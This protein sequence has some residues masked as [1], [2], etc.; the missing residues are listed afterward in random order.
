MAA[1]VEY[2]STPISSVTINSGTT[3]VWLDIGHA[4]M[5]MNGDHAWIVIASTPAGSP[6][7]VE[8][9]SSENS[10]DERP[11]ILINYTD[12]HSV[13]ISPSGSTTDADTQVQ[14]SHILN[15][16]LGGM[17]AEDV[18]WSVSDGSI[19]STGVFT[20][21]LVG[22]HDVTACFGVIC[23]TE[24]ITVTPGAP[25][26]LVVEETST[27]I[28]ADEFF[29]I[30]AH[31]EDQHGNE[32]GGELITYQVTNGSMQQVK[33]FAP[34]NSG[35]QTVT[36]GWGTQTIDVT[37]TVLGGLPVY[38]ETTGCED[39]IHA[40][41]TCQLNW[42]LHDQFGNMLNLEVGGGI[43]W[44]VGGG[45]FTESNGTFF[46]MTVGNYV[47]NMTSTGGIYHEIPIQITHGEMM[48]LEVNASETFVTADDIV[49]LNTTRIDIMGNRLSVVIPHENWTI[50]DGMITAGQPAEWHAQ[51]RGSKTL[52]ASYAGME[53]SVVV[54]VS[55]GAI[56]GLV[57]VI[58]SVD[59]TGSLQ[60]ITA[61][62][63]ITIK[64]KAV[65]SDGNRWTENVAWTI[66]H[67]QF[68]DQSVLQE[69]TYGSTTMFVPVFAS[70]TFYTLR[71]TYTD[72]NVTIE[73][74]LDISVDNGDLVSVSLIQPVSLNQ[75]IDAD[76]SLQFL[77]QL[78]D[79]DG[80]IIDSSIVSYTL[81]NLDSGETSDITS[82]IVGN[83]GIW[84]ATAVGNWSITAWAISSSGYNISET[85]T[86]SVEHGDA[87][88]V[89]IG[90]IA[91]TA[92][93]GDVY[94]LTITGT[95]ADGNTFLESVLWTQDN[96]AV[97]ASTIEGSGGEYNW[98]ATTA[99]EHT[100]KFRSPSGAEDTWTVTVVAHQT[101]NR[102]ELTIV[103]DSVLQLE[104]F[105]IEVRT[106]DAW[107]NEIPVPPETQVKLTGRMSAELT[108]N[109]KWTITTLDA[110]E[111]TVTISVHNKEVS[112]T[113]VVEGTFMGFFEAGGTLYYAGGILAILV[114]IVLLVVIVMVLRSG[115]SDYDDDDDDDDYEYEEEEEQPPA[116][117]G[118]S[119]PPLVE[120]G[121]EDWMTD[122]RLDEE[123][124]EWGEDENG[125]WWYRDPGT[126]EWS[127]WAD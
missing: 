32:V 9:Y 86:I 70:D 53:S 14:F 71:A 104:T 113:I 87:V 6:S 102:I 12:V 2:D 121:R 78:T 39:I 69:M 97:P 5:Q 74:T 20:P 99:G 22:T 80:N 119:G 1:G 55:E 88:T 91:N 98:S 112:D 101:V 93:A 110:E 84:E 36:V 43:S 34:Y 57:L 45:V 72:A 38:Y 109:G 60:E 35:I 116:A 96:K 83:A 120:R 81:E 77:P 7:W 23:T 46:A 94:D 26:T 100:F 63:E 67:N 29:T 90:V 66:E 47:I 117:A 64:V 85:V 28:T 4:S 50:S 42:T 31:V 79:G 58:D 3:E 54:Q 16:A 24:S 25:M 15:D 82:M 52:T 65:D 127:E 111:Q 122:Y 13:S 56:T 19:N 37:I 114:V 126:T 92:K 10:L 30:F 11:K 33:V 59:S 95:D 17:V 21:Q 62:D 40:G 48:S 18:V 75:N 44:T 105:D 124:V 103:D 68:T 8:F 108:E 115:G 61:D 73:V 27:T 107:E 123:D 118:P 49:W 51:R 76:N 41:E 89:E 106:F 125:T